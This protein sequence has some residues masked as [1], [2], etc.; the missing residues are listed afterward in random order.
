MTSGAAELLE[1]IGY[2][3]IR[4]HMLRVNSVLFGRLDTVCPRSPRV[5]LLS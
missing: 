2:S 3:R 5:P 1:P 4:I